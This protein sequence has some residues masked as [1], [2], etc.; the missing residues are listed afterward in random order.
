VWALWRSRVPDGRR[1][2]F[3]GQQPPRVLPPRAGAW[4]R[5]AAQQCVAVQPGGW[6]PVQRRNG[7]DHM[8]AGSRSARSSR[9]WGKHNPT[10]GDWVTDS[11]KRDRPR[12]SGRFVRATRAAVR[13][14]ARERPGRWRGPD[15][16]ATGTKRRW[17]GN[18]PFHDHQTACGKQGISAPA[19]AVD[20]ER[21]GPGA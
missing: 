18:D 1:A 2:G 6:V 11:A 16:L 10:R 17:Q 12:V 13:P 19:R 15:R 3:H 21:P 8:K 4:F 9:R 7:P 14:G 5:G 20:A